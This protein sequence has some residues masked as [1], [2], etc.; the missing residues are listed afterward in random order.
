MQT[1][2]NFVDLPTLQETLNQNFGEGVFTVTVDKDTEPKNYYLE[3]DNNTPQTLIDQAVIIADQNSTTLLNAIKINL[4]NMLQGKV[5]KTIIAK[6]KP[7]FSDS[8]IQE[9]NDWLQNMSGPVPT[10]VIFLSLSLSISN[11]LAAEKVA[12]S[13]IEY[14]NYINQVNAIKAMAQGQILSSSNV[15]DAKD[16]ATNA[17]AE[18]KNVA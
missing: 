12:N 11:Q 9:A 15:F 5:D 4:Y 2:I 10:C 13:K 18:I 7:K 16:I 1:L 14:D 17:S 6:E 3:Y 8:E